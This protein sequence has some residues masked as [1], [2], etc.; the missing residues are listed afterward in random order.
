MDIGRRNRQHD[1]AQHGRQRCWDYD[2]CR[3]DIK[4]FFD[5]IDWELL[6]A[7]AATHGLQMVLLYLERWLRAPVCMP[8]GN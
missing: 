8:D 1:A 3:S 5:D 2:W 7:G 4:S 6:N